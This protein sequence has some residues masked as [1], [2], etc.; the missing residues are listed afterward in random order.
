MVHRC[1]QY[2]RLQVHLMVRFDSLCAHLS[3]SFCLAVHQFHL[4]YHE[5]EVEGRKWMWC[6]V[7]RCTQ[8]HRFV[9]HLME[10]P[11]GFDSPSTV[12]RTAVPL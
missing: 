4:T 3:Y 11:L 9:W 7:H 8:Y 12:I 5:K 2:V 1:I 10:L 6:M